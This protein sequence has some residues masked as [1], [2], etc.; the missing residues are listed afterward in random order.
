MSI[1]QGESQVSQLYKIT[2]KIGL[3]YFRQA[4]GQKILNWMLLGEKGAL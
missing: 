1:P 2:G 4:A 3:V